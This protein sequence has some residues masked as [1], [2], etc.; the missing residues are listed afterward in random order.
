MTARILVAQRQLDFTQSVL[1]GFLIPTPRAPYL[2]HKS[3]GDRPIA[4]VMNSRQM[5]P[6]IVPSPERPVGVA[7]R[8]ARVL[9]N[10][11]AEFVEVKAGREICR[12]AT[13]T[14]VEAVDGQPSSN[15]ITD[16][17]DGDDG[18]EEATGIT[19]ASPKFVSP[20]DRFRPDGEAQRCDHLSISFDD[21]ANPSAAR[22]NITRN[23]QR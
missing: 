3:L 12:R 20:L 4:L 7:L 10:I 5:A 17:G 1:G 22:P 9:S 8:P 21:F 14:L 15:R 16:I 19:M 18:E 23:R 6:A 13:G 11:A 2:S